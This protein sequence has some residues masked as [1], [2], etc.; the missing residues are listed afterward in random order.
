MK[1]YKLVWPIDLKHH[2]LATVGCCGYI[3]GAVA[4]AFE[5]QARW[6]AAVFSGNC[7]L[8]SR[9]IM[10]KDV[11][12]FIKQEKAMSTRVRWMVCMKDLLSFLI[13]LSR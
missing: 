2:T 4:T 11:D 9:D 3:G 12:C 5:L 8:P 6:A 7:H 13:S 1:I 10:R